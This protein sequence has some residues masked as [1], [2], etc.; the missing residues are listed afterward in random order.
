[1]EG[2]DLKVAA[3]EELLQLQGKEEETIDSRIAYLV[4][5]TLPVAIGVVF[6]VLTRGA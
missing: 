6:I 2:I 3:D 4:L 1:M 5:V